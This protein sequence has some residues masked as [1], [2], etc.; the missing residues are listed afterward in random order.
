[1]DKFIFKIIVIL[2]IWLLGLWASY[3]VDNG[4]AYILGI[5]FGVTG[6]EILYKE[7]K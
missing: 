5:M 2:A 4:Q 7:D 3:K 6:Y 1:M